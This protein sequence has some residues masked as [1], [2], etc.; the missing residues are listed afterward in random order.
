MAKL[1][2]LLYTYLRVFRYIGSMQMLRGCNPLF[3]RGWEGRS[4]QVGGGGGGGGGG[5]ELVSS[6]MYTLHRHCIMAS[7]LVL[8]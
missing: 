1:P 7:S 6:Y 8:F 4:A 3:V 2:Q 5:G